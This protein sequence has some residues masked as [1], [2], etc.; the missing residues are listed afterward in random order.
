MIAHDD[1]VGNPAHIAHDQA[2]GQANDRAEPMETESPTT[3]E[4][5]LP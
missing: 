2:D 4:I 1:G 3:S 5:R